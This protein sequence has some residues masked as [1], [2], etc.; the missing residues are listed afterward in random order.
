MSVV[1]VLKLG[2]KKLQTKMEILSAAEA[3]PEKAGWEGHGYVYQAGAMAVI[4]GISSIRTIQ[5]T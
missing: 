2:A 5:E 4:S 1:V 3:G